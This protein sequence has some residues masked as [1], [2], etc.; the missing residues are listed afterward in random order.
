[1]R[2]TAAAPHP[3]PHFITHKTFFKSFFKSQHPHKSV[4][5]LFIL[6]IGKDKVTDCGGVDIRKT[7]LKKLYVR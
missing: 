2:V 1:M 3:T 4:N 6:V 7:T 5:I